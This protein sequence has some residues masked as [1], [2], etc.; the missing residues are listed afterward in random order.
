MIVNILLYYLSPSL[1]M[2]QMEHIAILLL[3]L[4]SSTIDALSAAHLQ[5]RALQR[6]LKTE[7]STI[8]I[9]KFP[10]IHCVFRS[11]YL[12]ATMIRSILDGLISVLYF[13]RSTTY[14]NYDGAI[15]NVSPRSIPTTTKLNEDCPLA[16]PSFHKPDSLWFSWVGWQ[17][18]NWWSRWI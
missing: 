2:V 11:Y 7:G 4:F 17:Q 9:F 14:N 10:G 5:T 12:T 16:V 6:I 13:S 8:S 3:L 15:F 18:W 1:M